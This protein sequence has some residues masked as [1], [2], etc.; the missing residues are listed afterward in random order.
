MD[1]LAE[2]P[3]EVLRLPLR[4]TSRIYDDSNPST[5]ERETHGE[6]PSN[7]GIALPLLLE[8]GI[9]NRIAQFRNESLHNFFTAVPEASGRSISNHS[10]LRPSLVGVNASTLPDDRNGVERIPTFQHCAHASS[11]DLNPA[12]LMVTLACDWFKVSSSLKIHGTMRH[13]LS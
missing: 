6:A 1:D 2:S 13:V 3:M 4:I 8:I 11:W 9:I 12:D 5:G 7:A 10:A